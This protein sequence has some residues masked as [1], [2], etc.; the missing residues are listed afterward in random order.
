[1]RGSISQA[2]QV[3]QKLHVVSSLLQIT[4]IEGVGKVQMDHTISEWK[5]LLECPVSDG[6]PLVLE[7]LQMSEHYQMLALEATR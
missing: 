4:K 5:T 7:R 1:M 2:F 6:S 3:D